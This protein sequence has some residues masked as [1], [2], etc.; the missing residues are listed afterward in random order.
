[1]APTVRGGHGDNDFEGHLM[2][3]SSTRMA[4]QASQNR[5]GHPGPPDSGDGQ[6]DFAEWV[7]TAWNAVQKK[8]L[9]SSMDNLS[10][11]Q[12]KQAVANLFRNT[13]KDGVVHRQTL[14]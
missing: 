13:A 14:W 9:P 12:A 1:M 3:S 10:H 8:A 4:S 2:G 11:E 6:L 7:Y 5:E